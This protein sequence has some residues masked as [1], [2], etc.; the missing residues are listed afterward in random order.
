M[1]IQSIE[2][3]S[4][5]QL[6]FVEVNLDNGVTGL[7]MTAP[8]AADISA[9]VMHRQIAPMAVGKELPVG[10]D[11][12]EIE[13]YAKKIAKDPLMKGSPGD[14]CE[15]IAWENYKHFGSHL[16][17]TLSGL[18]TALWDALGKI[19]G[20]PVC[21][22]LGGKR[23]PVAVYGS[24][25]DRVMPEED[26]AVRM[27]ALHEQ[28][29][30]A[31]KLHCGIINGNNVDTK[32]GRTERVVKLVRKAIG[33][34][35]L[36]VDVNGCYSPEY[37]ISKIPYLV[38][39]GVSI[40][41]EPCKYWELEETREVYKAA[42][43]MGIF[44]AGGEQD[45]MLSQWRG[46]CSPPAVDIVQPDIC[47]IGGF[48]RAI[49]VAQMSHAA[50]LRS[51]PHCSNHS[52]LPVFTSHYL[53]VAENS[54]PFMEYSIEDQSWTGGAIASMPAVKNGKLTPSAKPGWGEFVLSPDWLK[55]AKYQITK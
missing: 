16:F 5:P 46:Y 26:E 44:V 49:V 48:S 15:K 18:D 25:M 7:G 33:D 3:Y 45:Y 55:K 17:R 32:K 53:C 52:M 19:A 6:C 13:N 11:A 23:K 38:E 24:S 39:H 35:E 29:Y 54:F 4:S 41:E 34:A 22:L 37:A 1:K 51:T 21:S 31:F 43:S 27:K 42:K 28:G 40:L 30:G 47:Y 10:S 50:G 8:F 14:L 2:T 20:K 36:Y 9:M 12:K